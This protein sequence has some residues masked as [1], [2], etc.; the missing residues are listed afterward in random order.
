MARQTHTHTDDVVAVMENDQIKVLKAKIARS[1]RLLLKYRV[2]N[3]LHRPVKL[4]SKIYHVLSFCLLFVCF[5][6]SIYPGLV[7]YLE[8][9]PTLKI[10]ELIVLVW[11]S[12]EFLIK[13]VLIVLLLQ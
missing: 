1:K 10:L 2:Y 7:E 3:F 4:W 6:V 11:F 8:E 13:Y 9:R 5:F 12:V